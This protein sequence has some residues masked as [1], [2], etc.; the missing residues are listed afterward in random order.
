[1]HA[2]QKTIA[3]ARR[4]GDEL[5]SMGLLRLFDHSMSDGILVWQVA[6]TQ[7]LNNKNTTPYCE[8]LN[9]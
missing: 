1:M 7:L 5:D 8:E 6:V 4:S 2:A 9:I 3:T